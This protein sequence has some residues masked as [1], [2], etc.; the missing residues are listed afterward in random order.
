MKMGRRWSFQARDSSDRTEP[1][2]A[3]GGSQS[4]ASAGG[5]EAQPLQDSTVQYKVTR[6]C[7][8]LGWGG[9]RLWLWLQA[10]ALARVQAFK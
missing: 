5:A 1:D 7:T 9:G 4:L 10:L 2:V 6:T 8:A 3:S